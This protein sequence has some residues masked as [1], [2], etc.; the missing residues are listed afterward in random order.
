MEAGSD[1]NDACPSPKRFLLVLYS[2][3]TKGKRG[4]KRNNENEEHTESSLAKVA[5]CLL[6]QLVT[7]LQLPEKGSDRVLWGRLAGPRGPE[8]VE[9]AG[10][11]LA[12]NLNS[13]WQRA[14]C[15]QARTKAVHALLDALPTHLGFLLDVIWIMPKVLKNKADV[16]RAWQ[17]SGT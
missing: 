6:G 14:D 7:L 10:E 12:D 9:D 11:A 13:R 3:L 1:V 5:S 17:H 8:W 15:G 2:E 16:I 4:G